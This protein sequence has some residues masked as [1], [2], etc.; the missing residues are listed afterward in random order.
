V[1]T[2]AEEGRR[3]ELETYL[4]N[5]Y[6]DLY[7]EEVA[8]LKDEYPFFWEE[9]TEEFTGPVTTNA[10]EGGNWRLKEKLSVPY[11]RCRSAR[12]KVLLS[13]LND[14]LAVYSNGHPAA[15]F[16]HRH[17]SFSFKKNGQRLV[18]TRSCFS[19]TNATGTNSGD[20]ATVIFGSDS[21]Y[22]G[23]ST[24]SDSTENTARVPRG[25]TARVNRVSFIAFP[26]VLSIQLRRGLKTLI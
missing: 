7:E 6:T 24:T 26:V 2:L 11:R 12:G 19:S 22:G 25:L 9:E 10:I 8:D 4:E 13:V 5:E 3:E 1:D 17:G 14:S 20:V 23:K 18:T 15:S 16:A 21:R